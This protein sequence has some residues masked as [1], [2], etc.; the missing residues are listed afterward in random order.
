M[1]RRAALSNKTHCLLD[2]PILVNRSTELC[3]AWQLGPPHTHWQRPR[4][5]DEFQIGW[6]PV[7]VEPNRGCSLSDHTGI[8]RQSSEPFNS[9]TTTITAVLEPLGSIQILYLVLPGLL[10]R[11]TCWALLLPLTRCRFSKR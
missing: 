9:K 8:F 11:T 6:E 4:A 10:L 2:S 1:L 7:D 3:L 5:E